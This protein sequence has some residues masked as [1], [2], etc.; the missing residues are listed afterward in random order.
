MRQYDIL[1]GPLLTEKSDLQKKSNNQ[2][3]FKVD[4]RANR[5]EIKDAVERNFNTQVKQ[6]RTMQLKGKVKQRGRIIGKNKDW[7]KAIITLMPGHKI[8]F[9]EGV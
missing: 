9:F 2:V 1:R 6:V 4:R 8:G 5:V 3:T 7:K